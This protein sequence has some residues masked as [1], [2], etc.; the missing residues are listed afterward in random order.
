MASKK[1]RPTALPQALPFSRVDEH[2]AA[3]ADVHKAA[4]PWIC[5]HYEQ[6]LDTAARENWESFTCQRCELRPGPAAGGPSGVILSDDEEPD[7][8]PIPELEEPPPVLDSVHALALL[9]AKSVMPRTLKRSPNTVIN[10][11]RMCLDCFEVM[12]YSDEA[13]YCP[14]CQ[15]L[16]CERCTPKHA[17]EAAPQD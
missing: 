11:D 4:L 13:W 14:R 1:P 9:V 8:R 5:P 17:C 10:E 2:R 6:C 3:E 16:V 15:Q 7:L 12:H